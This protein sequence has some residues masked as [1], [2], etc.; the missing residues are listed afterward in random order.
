MTDQDLIILIKQLDAALPKEGAIVKAASF[1]ESALY[2][3]KIGYLRLGIELMKCA[4]EQ[5]NDRTGVSYLFSKDSDFSLEWLTTSE[6]E[7]KDIIS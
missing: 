7:F 5:T 4:F 2:A 3:N 1:G 6:D